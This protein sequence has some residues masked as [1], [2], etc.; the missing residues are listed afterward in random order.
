M[1][2]P[3]GLP[4][5]EAAGRFAAYRKGRFAWMLGRLVVPASQLTAVTELAAP[6][7]PDGERAIPWQVSAL[8][9]TDV[10]SDVA[11]IEA[12]NEAHGPGS[13]TGRAVV[14]SVEAKVSTP[15]D[16]ARAAALCPPGVRVAFELPPDAEPGS[17][18]EAIHDAGGIAKARL[19][20]VLPATVPGVPRV[21]RWLAGAAASRVPVK[22]TAGLH[23]AI[24]ADRAL[25]YEAGSPRAVMH[26]FLNVFV[27][28]CFAHAAVCPRRAASGR[29]A[30]PPDVNE[31]A[32]ALEGV[33]DET[34]PR[35]FT[36]DHGAVSWRGQA[37]S[38]A[39]VA[40]ARREFALSFGS[41][42]FEE[43][44]D[45]LRAMGWLP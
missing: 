37:L 14:D 12:F 2:P 20:G 36:V 30:S 17:F 7:L 22:A 38:V 42:S 1:F 34:D 39:Q 32:A 31:L 33:L 19:G 26:G 44:V 23:H 13:S 27:A 16:V 8:L 28:A 21:A 45:D 5:A 4:L 35:A 24:R 29:N 41:C 11:E 40:D 9:G 43:P 3:A 25:T 18:L 10:H 15:A 6:F